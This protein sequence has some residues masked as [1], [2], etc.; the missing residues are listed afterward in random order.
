MQ[1]EMFLSNLKWLEIVICQLYSAF[2]SVLLKVARYILN[3]FEV[4]K[5]HSI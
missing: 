4:V 2:F 3:K 1:Y 5:K